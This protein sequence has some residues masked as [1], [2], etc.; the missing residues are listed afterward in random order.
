MKKIISIILIFIITACMLMACSTEAER[1]NHNIAK[2]SNYFECERRV[3]VYNARTDK[4]ILYI[5]GYIDISNNIH[6]ELVVTAKVGPGKYK[7]NYVFLNDYTLYVVEDINGT[8]TD[9]Y[10]YKVYF[11][12]KMPDIEVK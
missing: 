3:T 4:V 8:H 5:E 2:Q 12:I 10:H 7:K 9:P 1:V 11:D 6:S